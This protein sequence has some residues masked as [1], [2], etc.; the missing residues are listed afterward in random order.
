MAKLK[1]PEGSGG[2]THDGILYEVKKGF[3]T[4]ADEAIDAIMA[5]ISHGFRT[6]GKT[7]AETDA[8]SVALDAQAAIDAQAKAAADEAAAAQA[9]ADAIALQAA[10]QAALEAAAQA[11]A[12]AK[13][14]AT[15]LHRVQ[16]ARLPVQYVQIMLARGGKKDKPATAASA[17]AASAPCRVWN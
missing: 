3:I 8:D 12:A 13:D 10:D 1:A 9:Q 17:P 7:D 15:F 2:M 4:I 6:T 14:D 11:E 16:V 5:A